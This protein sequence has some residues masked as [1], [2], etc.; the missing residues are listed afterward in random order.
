MWISEP[1]S[2]TS[3]GVFFATS[4]IY[5]D[6][7]I[8]IR[9]TPVWVLA[10]LGLIDFVVLTVVAFNIFKSALLFDLKKRAN[11]YHLVIMS[12]FLVFGLIH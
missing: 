10:K 6:Q 9:S 2:S 7:H 8:V 12:H 3:L 5:Y 1:V 4:R 11:A